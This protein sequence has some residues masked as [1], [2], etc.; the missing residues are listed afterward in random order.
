MEEERGNKG[1]EGGR[2][3]NIES[4]TTR[5]PPYKNARVGFSLH[6]FDVSLTSVQGEQSP[7]Q[8]LSSSSSS[9]Y[10]SAPLLLLSSLSYPPSPL[11]PTPSPL[12]P[13]LLYT[14][15]LLPPS[16]HTGMNT[17]LLDVWHE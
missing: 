6:V 17:H 14:P 10:S 9:P 1:G 4:L 11:S 13:L 15:M 3:I 8:L 5:E 7:P 16:T 12:H 2:G